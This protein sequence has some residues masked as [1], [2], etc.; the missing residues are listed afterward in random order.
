[1]LDSP[2]GIFN[3]CIL[4]VQTDKVGEPEVSNRIYLFLPFKIKPFCPDVT[5][6]SRR[7]PFFELGD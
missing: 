6:V 5:A 7:L 1:M 3:D 2:F 4:L